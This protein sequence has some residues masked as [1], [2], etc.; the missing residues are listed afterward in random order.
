M[1]PFFISE[2]RERSWKELAKNVCFKGKGNSPGEVKISNPYDISYFK[3]ANAY[4]EFSSG[5]FGKKFM[6]LNDNDNAVGVYILNRLQSEENFPSLIAPASFSATD[7]TTET[8][9]LTIKPKFPVYV[10]SPDKLYLWHREDLHGITWEFDNDEGQVC[11][12]LYG[13]GKTH[14]LFFACLRFVISHQNYDFTHVVI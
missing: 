11:L 7:L 1:S 13:W 14:L 8:E 9:E 6:R 5:I 12:D 10:K 4:G 3:Y 2:G